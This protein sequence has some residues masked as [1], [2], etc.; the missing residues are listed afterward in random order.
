MGVNHRQSTYIGSIIINIRFKIH[1]ACQLRLRLIA[2]PHHLDLLALGVADVLVLPLRA[3]LWNNAAT[4]LQD[5]GESAVWK[6]RLGHW[7]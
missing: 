5:D 4:L 3:Q 6:C 1:H 7:R 2:R